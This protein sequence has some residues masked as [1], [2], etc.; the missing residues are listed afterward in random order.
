MI[1][2]SLGDTDGTLLGF[3]KIT[4]DLTDRRN[5]EEALRESEERYRFFVNAIQGYAVF[6]LDPQGRV[7]TWNEGAQRLKGYAADEI[8]GRSFETFY[9][10]EDVAR[11]HPQHEL[12]IAE[13]EGRYEEEGWRVRKDGSRFRARVT[14]TAVRDEAGKLRGFAKVT[15]DLSEDEAARGSG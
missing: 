2:L 14:I 12:R 8:I 11:K 5:H 1:W 6:M 7:V 9:A 13:K 3:A 15:R 10:I 4:R